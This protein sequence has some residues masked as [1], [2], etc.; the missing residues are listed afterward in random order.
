MVYREQGQPP[1]IVNYLLLFHVQN[2][3][4]SFACKLE[5]KVRQFYRHR[6]QLDHGQCKVD[7]AYPA[8]KSQKGAA[9]ILIPLF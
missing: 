1:A 4:S 5:E 8:P 9:C 7:K 6:P 2:K 3:T